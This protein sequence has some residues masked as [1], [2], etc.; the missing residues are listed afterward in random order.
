MMHLKQQSRL[1][2]LGLLLSFLVV[3]FGGPHL[4][5][6]SSCP[7]EVL[8]YFP[9]GKIGSVIAPVKTIEQRYKSS[10]NFST[11]D[12]YSKGGGL[13]GVGVTKYASNAEARRV[14]QS[15]YGSVDALGV[16]DASYFKY[17]SG[18]FALKDNFI[19][20]VSWYCFC[21]AKQYVTEAQAK[22]LLSYAVAQI[23]PEE[24]PQPPKITS[25]SPGVLPAGEKRYIDKNGQV[26]YKSA[27]IKDFTVI[28]SNL[29]GAKFVSPKDS[30]G[31][32]AFQFY[33]VNVSGDGTSLTVDPYV[34]PDT[35]E[36]INTISIVNKSGLS[37]ALRVQVEISGTQYL[38]RKFAEA[39]NKVM[40]YGDWPIH[41][42]EVDELVRGISM[43][44]AAIQLPSY[45]SLGGIKID[46]YEPSYW[47]STARA[48]LC[49]SDGGEGCSKGTNIY[50]DVSGAGDSRWIA[51]KILHEAAHKLHYFYNG[52]Y[53]GTITSFFRSLRN[54]DW[55]FEEQYKTI[56]RSRGADAKCSFMPLLDDTHWRDGTKDVAHC[57]YAR[58]YGAFSTYEDIATMTETV[59]Y[60]ERLQS[61]EAKDDPRYAQ[62]LEPLRRYGFL[63]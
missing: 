34:T 43:G 29:F 10:C 37:A 56:A 16:G 14:F 52:T 58:A 60:P 27:Y 32:D 45:K 57:G 62:K 51:A 24:K 46:I 22:A 11:S 12:S 15:F 38:T 17:G 18:G 28:G 35:A 9:Q 44:L 39:S 33:G 7:Q 23:S 53:W 8:K 41:T 21:T 50:I 54:A 20:D 63:K 48:K 42:T 19:F 6:A 30:I 1:T 61:S 36:G 31:R 59:F 49:G 26:L 4:V 13:G 55:G 3:S 47:E 40:F 25:V 2:V 5:L